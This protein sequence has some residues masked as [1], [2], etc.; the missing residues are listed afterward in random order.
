MQVHKGTR[1]PGSKPWWSKAASEKSM[2]ELGPDCTQLDPY[3]TRA[4]LTHTRF[5]LGADFPGSCKMS[6]ASEWPQ[7][8]AVR[9]G[10]GQRKKLSLLPARIQALLVVS[11]TLHSHLFKVI[12]VHFKPSPGTQTGAPVK[13]TCTSPLLQHL[14]STGC[15]QGPVLAERDARLNRT[16]L[17]RSQTCRKCNSS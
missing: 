11:L 10:G 3:C 16:G 4:T 9:E 15:G 7:G 13:V 6:P 12:G 5:L 14:L 2:R 1:F 8:Q 17:R